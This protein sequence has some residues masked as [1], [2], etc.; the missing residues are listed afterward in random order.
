VD[1]GGR[2]LLDQRWRSLGVFTAHTSDHAKAAPVRVRIDSGRTPQSYAMRVDQTGVSID[3]A[4]GDGAFYALMTLAQLP[5]HGTNHWR[6]PCVAIEDAPALQWRILSDDVSRGPLP[7][8]AYFEERIRTIAAFKMN[9]YSPYMEHVF[10]DPRHPSAA[11]RDGITPDELSRLAVYAQR[12]HV[13]LI[14]QQ[15]TLAHMHGTLRW[16]ENAA[17]AETP[18]GFTIAPNVDQGRAY[19]A[20]LITDELAAVPNPPFFHLGADEASDVGLGRSAASI[21]T[22]G[23]E[24][25]YAKHVDSLINVLHAHTSARAMIWSDA[26]EQHPLLA[27]TLPHSTVLVNWHY[28]SGE[29]FDADVARLADLGF[30][31]MIAPGDWNWN[32]IFPDVDRA[33]EGERRFLAA[34]KDAHVLGLFQPVWHDDGETLDEATWYPVLYAAADAWE[35]NDLD[36]Q[37][38]DKDFPSAFFGSDDARLTH[39]VALLASA[40]N[41]LRVINRSASDPASPNLSDSS[42]FLFWANPLDPRMRARMRGA[43]DLGPIRLAAEGALDA[44]LSAQ[45]PLHARTAFVLQLAARRYDAL[46]RGFQ[47]ADEARAGYEAARM[48]PNAPGALRKLLIAKYLFWE[49]R[50]TL[51]D[52]RAMMREAW[53]YENRFSHEDAVLERYRLAADRAQHAADCIDTV[54]RID[55]VEHHPLPS[56][57]SL[58]GT[59]GVDS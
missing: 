18:H 15:Q 30:D 47:I 56:F 25:L 51:L 23:F 53:E 55:F 19:L 54:T 4:D 37:R 2:E 3:A 39:A 43:R 8:M 52:L 1:A 49:E 29:H 26:V 40:R 7:T 45:S 21:K 11:P 10:A 20:D 17:F 28:G 14:P 12:F 57:E 38:F 22:T 41:A 24:G 48:D 6:L 32:E 46:A 36:P 31:Q 34:G 44:V 42:D 13:T 35:R 5:S 16:E 9:G 58:L 50:D 33:I 27:H 59:C